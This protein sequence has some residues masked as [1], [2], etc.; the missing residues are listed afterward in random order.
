M[1]GD[2][3]LRPACRPQGQALFE[4]GALRG[5][6]VGRWTA[7]EFIRRPNLDALQGKAPEGGQIDYVQFFGVFPSGVSYEFKTTIQYGAA[8]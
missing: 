3:S 6:I 8:Q 7:V 2:A 1:D 5:E 4:R